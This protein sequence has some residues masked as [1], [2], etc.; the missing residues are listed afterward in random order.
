[1]NYI[2]VTCPDAY[3]LTAEVNQYIAQGYRPLGDL[4][5]INTSFGFQLYQS[6]IR[7]G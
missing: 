5:A 1:M 2:V 3:S 7:G 4:I 6:M